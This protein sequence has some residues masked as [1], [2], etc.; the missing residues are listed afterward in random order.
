MAIDVG[1]TVT[2]IGT[3]ERD[4]LRSDEMERR[5][6]GTAERWETAP[7]LVFETMVVVLL[8]LACR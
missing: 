4:K 1:G 3:G 6:E 2:V 5:C 8:V 7:A